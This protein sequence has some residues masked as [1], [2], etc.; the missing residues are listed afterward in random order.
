VSA[1]SSSCSAGTWAL[2]ASRPTA[3]ARSKLGPALRTCAGA[4]FHRQPLLRELEPG[5]EQR[6]PHTLARLPDRPVREPHEHERGQAPPDV[7]LN[8]DLLRVN[9]I[10]C[11]GGD[12]GEHPV[13]VH[14]PS[15]TRG[16]ANATTPSHVPSGRKMERDMSVVFKTL[17][18]VLAASFLVVVVLEL[19][20]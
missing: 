3:I 19:M 8:G 9:A 18:G 5:V 12:R 13:E 7:H 1:Q 10:E 6:R 14:A 15:A 2:A 11:E 4:R 17:T 20:A 16:R